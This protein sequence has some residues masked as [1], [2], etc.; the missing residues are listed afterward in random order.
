MWRAAGI[1]A[2]EQDF[3]RAVRDVCRNRDRDSANYLQIL[4][5]AYSVHEGG[6]YE[7]L[8]VRGGPF[9]MNLASGSVSDIQTSDGRKSL[10]SGTT[11]RCLLPLPF[12][13]LSS[14]TTEIRSDDDEVKQAGAAG[15]GAVYSAPGVMSSA[16]VPLEMHTNGLS[17]GVRWTSRVDRSKEGGMKPLRSTSDIARS[18]SNGEFVIVGVRNGTINHVVVIDGIEI[19]TKSRKIEKLRV[20]DPAA[21]EVRHSSIDIADG[22]RVRELTF[23]LSIWNL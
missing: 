6:R 10:W 17:D 12:C 5:S 23:A 1:G 16:V 18:I 11:I 8:K 7:L 13:V 22:D 9:L 21:N 2:T 15:R 14:G 20:L 3:V 19:N 4:S